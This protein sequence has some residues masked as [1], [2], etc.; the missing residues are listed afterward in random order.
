MTETH[1]KIEVQDEIYKHYIHACEKHPFFADEM[2]R[3]DYSWYSAAIRF[4][5][6]LKYQT[7]LHN[8]GEPTYCLAKYVLDAELAEVYDAYCKGNYDQAVEE[9][10]DAIAVLLRMGDMIIDKK[11]EAAHDER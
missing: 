6:Y 5:E 4:K 10:Y 7:V 11:Q 9:I 1:L 2:C 8:D 3:T